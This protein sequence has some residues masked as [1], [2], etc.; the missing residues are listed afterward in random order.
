MRGRA[1]SPLPAIPGSSSGRTRGCFASC[2]SDELDQ[3]IAVGRRRD[4]EIALGIGLAGE[5]EHRRM[6]RSPTAS[7]SRSQ[8]P[9]W[10]YLNI[11]AAS[12]NPFA[13]TLS[14][15]VEKSSIVPVNEDGESRDM[16]VHA[17]A[18]RHGLA[19]RNAVPE[20]QRRVLERLKSP[21]PPTAPPI[22][23]VSWLRL[24]EPSFVKA[25]SERKFAWTALRSVEVDR[26]VVDDACGLESASR[27]QRKAGADLNGPGVRQR[28]VDVQKR[29]AILRSPV[30]IDR[31][32]VGQAARRR[33]RR[34]VVELKD[35]P[36]RS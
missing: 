25:P 13:T 22:V 7:T 28:P 8:S 31:A 6:R 32:A 30:E 10:V 23:S 33:Q 21:V 1:P 27:R 4:R 36:P 20:L 11:V 35:R 16:L 14:P 29:A 34:A 24:T 9:V 18:E 17:A 19:A 12:A 5:V 3:R 2:K 26:P 15:A